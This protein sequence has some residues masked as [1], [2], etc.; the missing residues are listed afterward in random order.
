MY[1][2]DGSYRELGYDGLG[3]MSGHGRSYHHHS[4]HHYH[5]QPMLPTPSLL[6]AVPTFEESGTRVSWADYQ[7]HCLAEVSVCALAGV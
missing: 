5:R 7:G 4:S 6:P 1:P 3:H 2:Y